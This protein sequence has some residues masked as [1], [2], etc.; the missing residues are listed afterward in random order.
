M[1]GSAKAAE[2]PGT[3]EVD[4]EA[5]GPAENIVDRRMGSSVLTLKSE[6]SSWPN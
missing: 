5:E 2:E 3:D 6:A 4:T 1:T